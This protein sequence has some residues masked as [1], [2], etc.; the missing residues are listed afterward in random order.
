M[1]PSPRRRWVAAAALLVVA[2][3]AGLGAVA[4]SQSSDDR[5]P[6][7]AVARDV[8]LGQ[9][10]GPQDLVVAEVA[11]DPAL[12]P[13]SSTR[14]EELVGQFAAT[15]LRAGTLLTAE[16][17]I[18][19]EIVADGERLIGV[20]VGRSRMPLDVLVPGD[21]VLVVHTPGDASGGA[22][23]GTAPAEI[24]AT[25]RAL[26]DADD[27]STAA[28]M[29]NLAVAETDGPLLAMWA[30]AGDVTLVLEPRG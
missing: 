28:R 13:V 21:Q 17:V 25:V 7:I 30:A 23:A 19:E 10:I 14:M 22:G 1:T 8:P 3:L 29:V 16:Q 20:E 2:V 24:R 26:S 27:D 18:E 11:D 12:S 9:E 6:V 15:E 5:R 4:W